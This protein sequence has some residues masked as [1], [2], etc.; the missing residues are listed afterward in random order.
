MGHWTVQVSASTL[1][2]HLAENRNLTL[3]V[4]LVADPAGQLVH[5]EV[6]E[7]DGE[8]RGTFRS[9]DILVKLL[10]ARLSDL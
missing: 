1:G 6:V 2:E 10:Q 4:R 9:W 5:G 3:L 7:L 8:P